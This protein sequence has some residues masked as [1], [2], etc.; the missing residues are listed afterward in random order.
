MTCTAGEGATSGVLSE[1]I[2][3]SKLTISVSTTLAFTGLTVAQITPTVKGHIKAGVEAAISGVTVASIVASD[4]DGGGGGATDRRQLSSTGE[5]QVAMVIQK[6][7]T[8]TTSAAASFTA[9]ASEMTTKVSGGDVS[10]QVSSRV[11]AAF[12]MTASAMDAY[13]APAGFTAS[14]CDASAFVNDVAAN[15][16]TADVSAAV[17]NGAT[18]ALQM[19]GGMHSG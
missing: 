19:S 6:E 9:L 8:G 10:A 12:K 16:F 2:V 14:N 15:G 5:V 11:G 13:S 18:A 4:G 17:T 7:T 1:M 3:C